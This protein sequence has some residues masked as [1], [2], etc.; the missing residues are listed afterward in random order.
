MNHADLRTMTLDT[1]LLEKIA[2][3]L[4]TFSRRFT[5]AFEILG[6]SRAAAELAR[7][8]YYEEAKNCIL[9]VEQM[10]ERKENT[11]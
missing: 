9:Q 11:L 10:K 5:V 4:R 7:L 6:Y 2:L 3:R 8:G 1:S